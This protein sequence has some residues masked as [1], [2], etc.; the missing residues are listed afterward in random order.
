MFV[1]TIVAVFFAAIPALAAACTLSGCAA[2]V[3]AIKSAETPAVAPEADETAPQQARVTLDLSLPSGSEQL[4]FIDRRPALRAANEFG[5]A[6]PPRNT[7]FWCGSPADQNLRG[8]TCVDH[9]FA[10]TRP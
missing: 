5:T 6:L 10:V 1:R 2:P 8:S 4:A 9:P 3:T 7:L